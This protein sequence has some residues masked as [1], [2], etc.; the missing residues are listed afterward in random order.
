[1]ETQDFVSKYVR[2]LSGITDAPR[3]FQET[4]ALFLL[5]TAVGRK[6]VFQS[7]PETAIFSD[8][9][10]TTGKLL[11]LW[12]IIIGKSR[13][14]R[15]S[16]GVMSRVEEIAKKIFGEQLLISEAFTPESLIKEMS[17]KSSPPKKQNRKIFWPDE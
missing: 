9:I 15:K 17:E 11:N 13:I 12:F 8:K 10:G 7:L 3:E 2:L 16:S 5:S 4:A 14:T 1:M 6:W